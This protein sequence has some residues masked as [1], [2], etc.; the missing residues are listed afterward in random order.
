MNTGKI[1][2]D[3][4]PTCGNQVIIPKGWI[5]IRNDRI[6]SINAVWRCPECESTGRLDIGGV[7]NNHWQPRDIVVGRDVPE[8]PRTGDLER[9]TP[10]RRAVEFLT[11]WKQDDYRGMGKFIPPSEGIKDKHAPVVM[12]DFYE[13]YQLKHLVL[14]DIT[15]ESPITSVVKVELEMIRDGSVKEKQREVKMTREDDEGSDDPDG[16]WYI[17]QWPT[18][19]SGYRYRG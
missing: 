18:L 8:T 2:T 4:C 13:E 16:N 7:T 19:G 5:N 6:A 12:K 1:H 9:G 11:Y 10:E 15:D 3:D 14:Q 17:A